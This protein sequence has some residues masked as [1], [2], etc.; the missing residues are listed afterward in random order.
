[1]KVNGDHAIRSESQMSYTVREAV[2]ADAEEL[3]RLRWDFRTEEQPFPPQAR[4]EFLQECAAWLRRALGSGR[5]VVA[6]AETEG[7]SLCGCMYLEA[8]D[9]VPVPGSIERAWGYVT[10]SYVA[11]EHRNLG[12]GR[13]LLDL[14][15]AAGR[16]RDL[17]FLIVWPSQP[18]LP[19]YGRAGFLPV[20]EVLAGPDDEPPLVLTL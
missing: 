3:A 6:V 1:M 9:K 2:Q 14:L 7:G 11:P 18:A 4:I 16:V 12:L 13:R 5:W 19:F 20:A 8:V 15:I 10:N 17:E